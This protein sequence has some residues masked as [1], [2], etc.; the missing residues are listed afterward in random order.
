[1]FSS[2]IFSTN[3]RITRLKYVEYQKKLKFTDDHSDHCSMI[4]ALTSIGALQNV[5]L[6]LL[7][8]ENLLL[9]FSRLIWKLFSFL[10]RWYF[11]SESKN[12]EWCSLWRFYCGNNLIFLNYQYKKEI[13]HTYSSKKCMR[14]LSVSGIRTHTIISE[15]L[16]GCRKSHVV[17]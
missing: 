14:V 16:L 15:Y 12:C 7:Y 8:Q 4:N 6:F 10:I 11:F 5:R 13:K 3:N 1:M 9:T 2:T 17:Y